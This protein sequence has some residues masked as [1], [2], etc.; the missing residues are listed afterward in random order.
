MLR[1][2]FLLFLSLSLVLSNFYF[3]TSTVSAKK[4]SNSSIVNISDDDSNKPEY[5][6]IDATF[7]DLLISNIKS[8]SQKSN[9]GKGT[10]KVKL[11]LKTKKETNKDIELNAQLLKVDEF[12][13]L[14]TIHEKQIFKGKKEK[15]QDLTEYFSFD[16]LEDG[17]YEINFDAKSI[18]SDEEV[19]GANKKIYF[20]INNN[21]ITN[22]WN[23]VE[24]DESPS[25]SGSDASYTTGN[26]SPNSTTTISGTYKFYDRTNS[27]QVLKYAKVKLQYKDNLY[28]YRDIATTYTDSYGKWSITFTVPSNLADNKLM[29][30]VYAYSE[31]GGYA[32]V[33]NTSKIPYSYYYLVPDGFASG[34]I[35]SL[36]TGTKTTTNRKAI[37]LYD[38]IIRT[39]NRLASWKD[40][41]AATAIWQIG[42]NPGTYY[43]YGNNIYLSEI[44]ANSPD[45][46][47]HELGH[48]YMYNLYSGWYPPTNCPSPHYIDGKSEKGCAW[49]EGWADF[50]PLYIN[51]S[52]YYH[53]GD[54][55]SLNLENTSNFDDYGDLVEGRVAG[56]LWDMYDVGAEGSDNV[57]NTFT[58]IYNAMYSQNIPDFSGYWSNW[59]RLGYS[60]DAKNALTQNGINY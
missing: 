7:D 8:Y 1:G 44:D 10:G 37:W 42:Y 41:G 30:K 45:T 22:G 39:K 4:R 43:T 36:Y 48:N 26:V 5:L 49:S 24:G 18:Q 33:W 20:T 21:V 23:I 60:S 40:P 56:S 28:I 53:W 27:S 12:G 19:W 46:I 2:I 31:N 9:K 29:L 17:Q 54:G 58:K 11:K 34:N 3:S 55:T 38:D 52:S 14:I 25:E 47:I 32:R 15:D 16:S 51:N 50:L 6:Q 59:I 57:S 13:G 35:G